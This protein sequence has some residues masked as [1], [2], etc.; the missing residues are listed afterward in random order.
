MTGLVWPQI[1]NFYYLPHCIIGYIEGQIHTHTY[2][3]E[4]IGNIRPRRL[5][6]LTTLNVRCARYENPGKI[7][8]NNIDFLHLFN[9]H[10]GF[11]CLSFPFIFL[12]SLLPGSLAFPSHVA[13][14]KVIE[15]ESLENL[16][17]NMAAE[18]SQVAC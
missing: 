8:T 2:T 6:P 4:S 13:C 12:S 9:T 10:W 5:H 11:P 7:Q 16:H 1:V 18:S 15:I 14:G 3:H 17:G